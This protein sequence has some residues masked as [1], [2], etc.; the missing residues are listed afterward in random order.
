MKGIGMRTIDYS[1]MLTAVSFTLLGIILCVGCSPCKE[2][3]GVIK[4]QL[5]PCWQGD[6]LVFVGRTVLID[7]HVEIPTGKRLYLVD[8]EIVLSGGKL[9]IM[10]SATVS[11]CIIK[12]MRGCIERP[13]CIEG[14]G[15]QLFN[16]RLSTFRNGTSNSGTRVTTFH[17]A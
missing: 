9:T 12:V 17:P 11:N 10:G 6:I 1:R 3:L 13:I 16:S 4:M 7:E 8:C 5:K 15:L 2:R 14:G